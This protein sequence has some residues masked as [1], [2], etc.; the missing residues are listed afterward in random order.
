MRGP[1]PG[2]PAPEAPF[3]QE[4]IEDMGQIIGHIVEGFR[5]YR[6]VYWPQAQGLMREGREEIGEDMREAWYGYLDML[7][8]AFDR[9]EF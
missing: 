3:P 1:M 7:R 5:M 2:P 4:A 9:F 6:D 8:D